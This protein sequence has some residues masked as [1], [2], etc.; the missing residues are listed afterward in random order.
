MRKGGGRTEKGE[1]KK[2]DDGWVPCVREW[3]VEIWKMKIASLLDYSI[4]FCSYLFLQ[5]AKPSNLTSKN[6]D[7]IGVA[8]IPLEQFKGLFK[9]H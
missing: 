7:V 8:L 4:K 9:N 5:R 3:W 1:G 2:E 6:K